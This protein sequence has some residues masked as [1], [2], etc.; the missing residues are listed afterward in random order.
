[1]Y[2]LSFYSGIRTFGHQSRANYDRPRVILI[3]IFGFKINFAYYAVRFKT[4]LTP[5]AVI[6]L[7]A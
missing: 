5:L 2:S 7:L 6:C 1:M 4:N 3:L